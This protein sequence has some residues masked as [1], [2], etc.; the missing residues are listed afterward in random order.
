MS[1]TVRDGRLLRDGQ[2]FLAVG[3]DYHPSRA[4]CRMWTEWDPVVLRRDFG[5]MAG[6]GLNTVRF[7]VFWRDFEP[8]PG[9]YETK[10][11]D[12]L[13]ETVELAGQA[14]LA[15]LVSLLTIWM[16]GQRL[17]LPW[18]RGRS[19]WRDPTLLAR[20]EAFART[21]ATALG[22]LDN[23]LAIDLGDEI[24]NV[25]TGPTVS[26]DEVAAW[27]ARLA[28]ALR[29]A[30]PG[31]LV[32]QAN[33]ASGV[34]GPA[35]FGPDNAAGLDLVG[36]HGF[37]TWAPGAI[38]S[39]LSYKATNLVP[40]LVRY[41]AAYGVPIVDE[42]GSYG[43]DEPTAARYLGA[44]AASA[45]ANGAAGIA[46]WCWQDVESRAEPYQDRP[47]E[48]DAGLHRRDGTA[49]P[50]MAA[51]RQVA[52]AA[53]ALAPGRSRAPIALYLPQ[54]Q[55]HAGT[56]YLDTGPGTLAT[57]FAYLMLKRAH[58]DFDVVAGDLSG[59]RLVLCPSVTHV[60][61]TDLDRLAGH[62]DAGGVLWYSLGDHLHGFPGAEL[63]GV[64]R[65][66]YALTPAGKTA[67]DW[68]GR[69]WP[70]DWRAAAARPVTVTATTAETVGRYRDGTGAVFVNGGRV[71][72][73]AAPLARQ[74][75]RP[76][77]L[78]RYPWEL[79]YR[80]LARLAG[81]VPDPDCAD[82]DVEVVPDRGPGRRAVVVNHGTAPARP[83]LSWGG[84][85]LPVRLEPKE[86]RIVRRGAQPWS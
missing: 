42:L 81:V 39:T 38:E 48:R 67:V 36:I 78:T 76:G 56:S 77:R 4:G 11:L 24:G 3:V 33:D 59:Y 9:R 35:P 23:L 6:T 16:N 45:L 85:R 17:D 32:L 62:V 20:Q 82:P 86:W 58:L 1:F 55:R 50:A 27:Q 15:C 40:F 70:L 71:V 79:L 10:A 19:L 5:R 37:P 31:T 57:W 65:V 75:D 63:M 61:A 54:R 34:L 14:G 28:G 80:D 60:T 72:F 30:R 69:Q 46:A 47:G 52:A 25:E 18:R 26:R 64:E 7:F 2:P 83:E 22:G 8:E 51:L 84:A 74:L 73:C 12:R 43:V 53:P 41:A 49:K 66:D 68:A 29:D 13:R 44:A 21:V